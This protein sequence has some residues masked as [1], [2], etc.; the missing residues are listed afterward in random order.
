[1]TSIELLQVAGSYQGTYKDPKGVNHEVNCVLPLFTLGDRDMKGIVQH[2]F[3][4]LLMTQ[5][6]V[7]S[8]NYNYSRAYWSL[9]GQAWTYLVLQ[10]DNKA[11][12]RAQQALLK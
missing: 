9:L 2:P 6:V 8:V 1:M 12:A 5:N 7:N 4:S 11:N 3:F 10:P